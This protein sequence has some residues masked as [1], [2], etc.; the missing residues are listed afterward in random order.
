[1]LKISLY[2][3]QSGCN[4][5]YTYKE[6]TP[7]YWYVT[8]HIRLLLPGHGPSRSMV[9]CAL[10]P[11]GLPLGGRPPTIACQTAQWDVC[12]ELTSNHVYWALPF[13]LKPYIMDNQDQ[14]AVQYMSSSPLR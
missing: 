9:I 2:N 7:S 8:L 13:E 11:R 4:E 12:I 3:S 10:Q 6:F 14:V 1:M 5:G